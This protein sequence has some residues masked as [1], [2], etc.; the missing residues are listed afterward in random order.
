[1]ILTEYIEVKLNQRNVKHFEDKGYAIPIKK[2]TEIKKGRVYGYNFG[3][4]VKIK[5]CDA[6]E[7]SE[8]EI[9]VACDKCGELRSGITISEYNRLKKNYDGYYCLSCRNE[10]DK[11]MLKNIFGID[12]D[13]FRPH[14]ESIRK[15]INISRDL[16]YLLSNTKDYLD[17]FDSIFPVE[18]DGYRTFNISRV[19]VIKEEIV[20]AVEEKYGVRNVFQAEDIKE[21]IIKTNIEKYGVPHVMQNKAVY[22]KLKATCMER[23]GVSHFMQNEDIKSKVRQTYIKKYG[24]VSPSQYREFR[25]RAAI[26]TY[27]NHP[28]NL[29]SS[30][31]QDYIAGLLGGI[32]NYPINGYYGDIVQLDKKYDIEIDGSGHWLSME[33]QHLTLDEFNLREQNRDQILFDSG[34]KVIRIISSKDMFPSNEIIVSMYQYADDMLQKFPDKINTIIFNIDEEVVKIDNL[35]FRMYDY[36]EL[37]FLTKRS[38]KYA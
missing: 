33:I 36:G 34:Y 12:Y 30:A 31:S 26:T 17:D 23:Y 25:Q 1:M 6:A 15:D 11:S 16:R 9:D 4:V 21:T 27:K 32:K 20:N 38:L 10:I 5:S 2:K 28:E 22:A 7:Y 19:P 37:R 29:K 35:F 14:K 8:E 3:A 18:E 13:E 24:V